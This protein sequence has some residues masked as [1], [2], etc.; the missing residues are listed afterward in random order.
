MAALQ[1]P[2][3]AARTLFRTETRLLQALRPGSAPLRLRSP[4]WMSKPP[5]EMAA[6][7]LK[8]LRAGQGCRIR[9]VE[10]KRCLLP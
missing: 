8:A 3:Q 4:G 6:R 2:Q 5:S 7:W 9:A 1:K 10:A